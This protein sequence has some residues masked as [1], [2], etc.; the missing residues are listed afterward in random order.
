MVEANEIK[1]YRQKSKIV[2]VAKR[3]SFVVTTQ[4][5]RFKYHDR[6]VIDFVK[7]AAKEEGDQYLK[8]KV[9]FD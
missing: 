5:I 9:S 1:I 4:N 7:R 8:H 2:S 3:K 6:L